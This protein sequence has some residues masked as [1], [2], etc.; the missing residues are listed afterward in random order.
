MPKKSLVR[1]NVIGRR[2][3]FVFDL[4]DVFSLF[5]IEEILIA[6]NFSIASKI[7]NEE[8]TFTEIELCGHSMVR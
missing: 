1:G 3:R 7:G 4:L 6:T 8:N 5:I 2:S